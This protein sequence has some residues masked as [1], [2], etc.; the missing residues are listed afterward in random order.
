MIEVLITLVLIAAAL[1]G[2]AGMQI[3]G[4][5][6]TQGS[7]FRA[8]A[9]LLTIDVMERLE[10]NNVG[11]LEARYVASLPGSAGAPD[12]ASNACSPAD[13]AQYDLNLLQQNLA[14]QLPNATA[15]IVRSGTGPFVY[16][17]TVNWQERSFKARSSKS[18]NEQPVETFS[19]TVS[20][21]IYNR[22]AMI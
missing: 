19:Y 16:T 9:I 15:T 5:K 21:T 10:A 22:A 3:Y 4:V 11:A 6:V 17:L 1:L 7:Q 13:L 8:Q 18:A 12:C 14:R 20:R 2:T